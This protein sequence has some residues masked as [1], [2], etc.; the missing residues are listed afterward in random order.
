MSPICRWAPTSA[1]SCEPP[2]PEVASRAIPGPP[3]LNVERR[4]G[5]WPGYHCPHPVA[6]AERA[7]SGGCDAPPPEK[8]PGSITQLLNGAR[9]CKVRAVDLLRRWALRISGRP[10]PPPHAAIVLEQ[11]PR[12]L[13]GP[14]YR[15]R[16]GE[17]RPGCAG[18]S[19][20]S[21]VPR[22]RQHPHRPIRCSEGFR[23]APGS[24]PPNARRTRRVRHRLTS[25]P[26]S[27]GPG[28][29]GYR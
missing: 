25:C 24:T 15:R 3:G 22:R 4:R 5:A 8:G 19:W 23:R 12:R 29:T 16:W 6:G 13:G 11:V 26:R 10:D 27:R 7:S 1:R 18:G 21:G 14:K 9:D 28:G 20:I 2:H 17:W